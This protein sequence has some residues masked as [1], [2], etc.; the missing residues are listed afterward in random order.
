MAGDTSVE[1][2]SGDYLS[3]VVAS[4]NDSH[5]GNI[6]KRMCLF[7]S[8]LLAQTRQY[9]FPLE[10]VFVEWNP[11][12]DKPRL[13][14]VLPK[15]ATGDFLTLRYITVPPSLHQC[16]RRA[17]DIPLFQMIAKNVG[18][19]RAK[20]SLI[21]CTNIDLLF[22]DALFQKLT[23]HSLRKDAYYRASRCDVPETIDPAW[24]FSQQL[25]WCERNVI[26]RL[27][28]DLRYNNVNMELIGMQ[29]KSR[30]KKWLANKLALATGVYWSREKRIFH[31][32]DLFACG[33]FTM[34]SREAWHAIQGYLEL[35][36]Y[37]LH[38]DSLALIAAAAVGYEQCVFPPDACT[39]HICHPDSW[40][41]MAP[42]EKLRFLSDRPALDYGLMVEVGLQTL[43]THKPY[44]LNPPNWGFADLELEELLFAPERV[45]IPGCATVGG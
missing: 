6:Q 10:L 23:S 29:A 8:G 31:E 42:L 43:A 40:E 16:F 22:S 4:R 21:L 20:G 19:R 1:S 35:D 18:I 15:P 41:T 45:V 14:E 32:L 3:I 39:Y 37:S 28:R 33:D 27:G 24:P 26:R 36:L 17:L 7:V 12:A 44:N 34:M 11:P 5:G 2:L 13:F 38:I 30:P 9:R 25:A